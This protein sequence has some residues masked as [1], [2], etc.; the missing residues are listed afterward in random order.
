MYSIGLNGVDDRGDPVDGKDL[1]VLVGDAKDT[2]QA[3]QVVD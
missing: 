1:V 3:S 2:R